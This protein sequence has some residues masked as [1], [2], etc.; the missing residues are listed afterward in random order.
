MGKCKTEDWFAHSVLSTEEREALGEPL[1]QRWLATVRAHETVGPTDP[2]SMQPCIIRL[3][4]R[5]RDGVTV[6][7]DSLGNSWLSS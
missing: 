1:L 7:D 3:I 2:V 6:C 5:R 4:Y